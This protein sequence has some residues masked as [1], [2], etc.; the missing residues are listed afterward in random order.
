MIYKYVGASYLD[1]VFELRNYVTLKC[2]L[3][4]DFNDPYELFLTVNYREKPEI[5]AFYGDVVGDLPQHPVTCFSRSPAILPMWAHYAENLS[6]VV[7]AFDEKRLEASLTEVAFG[8][9]DYRT[10][11]DPDLTEMLHMA[12]HIGKMRYLYFLGRGVFSSAYYSK[13]MCWQ[14]EQERRML[15]HKKN[16][17][18]GTS[19]LLADV[20]NTCLNAIIS[21]PRATKETLD[22]VAEKCHLARCQNYKLKIGRS[23]SD[24]YFVDDKGAAHVFKKTSLAK[25]KRECKSCGEPLSQRG[26]TCSWCRITFDHKVAAARRN[27]LRLLAQHGML[28]EY[29]E[30]MD[31][32]GRGRRRK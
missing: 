26:T 24:P 25:A 6:G 23:T 14:Y 18:R 19:L 8:D 10:K 12:Y 27:L 30:G 3:P 4:K 17:R 32:I 28:K 7:L 13:A 31:E 29:V 20:P 16:M 1:R 2:S 15:V 11:P 22:L 5:L 21:G 9:I